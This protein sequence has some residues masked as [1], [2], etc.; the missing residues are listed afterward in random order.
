MKTAVTR[1]PENIKTMITMVVTSTMI[2]VALMTRKVTSS[3]KPLND[4]VDD[5][6]VVDDYEDNLHQTTIWL[7]RAQQAFPPAIVSAHSHRRTFLIMMMLMII[8]IMMIIISMIATD[9]DVI[10][11]LKIH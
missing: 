6:D 8:L 9:D 3:G 4:D 11:I 10:K 5:E 7:Q 1:I 2:I